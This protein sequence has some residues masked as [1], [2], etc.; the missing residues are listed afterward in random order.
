MS[1]KVF[2]EDG[3]RVHEKLET[4]PNVEDN[5]KFAHL[6]RSLSPSHMFLM[7]GRVEGES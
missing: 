2:G 5:F 7:H 1:R 4:H 3:T 6:W